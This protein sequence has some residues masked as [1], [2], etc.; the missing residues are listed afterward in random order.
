VWLEH[1]GIR[2]PIGT[3]SSSDNR[4]RGW[5]ADHENSQRDGDIQN[6]RVQKLAPPILLQL[7]CKRRLN[8]LGNV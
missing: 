4:T 3:Q 2:L 1:L 8:L 7:F 5:D 6:L